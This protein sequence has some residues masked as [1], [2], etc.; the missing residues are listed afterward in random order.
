[1]NKF[2]QD[3]EAIERNSFWLAFIKRI[4]DLRN[5]ELANIE[6]QDVELVPKTQGKL[7]ILKWVLGLPKDML[8]KVEKGD[9]K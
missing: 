7:F 4:E 6:S 1:M 8:S 3:Y 9:N 5:T 2:L